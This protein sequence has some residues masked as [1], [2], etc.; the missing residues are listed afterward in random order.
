MPLPPLLGL[1]HVT[2]MASDVQATYQLMTQVLGLRLIKQTVNQDQL[3][4]YHFYFTDDV[5]TPGT[6]LTFFFFPHQK[7]AVRGTNLIAKISFRVPNDD[8]LLQ[9]ADR[10]AASGIESSR[11]T[12]FGDAGLEFNDADAQVYQLISDR[13]ETSPARSQPWTHSSVPL[14][15]AIKGL[16]PITINVIN[17]DR[18]AFVLT[19]MLGCHLLATDGSKQLFALGIGGHS[20]QVI[21]ATKPEPLTQAGF[22]MVHHVAFIT[23]DLTSLQQWT[24]ALAKFNLPHSGIVNRFYFQSDYFRPGPQLLF[25]IATKGPGFFQ[26]EPEDTAGQHLILPPFLTSQREQILANLPTFEEGDVK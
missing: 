1:H 11:V 10:L 20:Q 5:G 19:D 14:D 8:A 21:L 6:D 13:Y 17:A 7:S 25:E 16:G 12:Q 9:W 2:A 3:D 4:T 23:E 26:D 22:G 15:M 24:T 18:L